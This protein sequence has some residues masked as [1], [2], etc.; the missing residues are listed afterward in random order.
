[1]IDASVHQRLAARPR[2]DLRD[3]RVPRPRRDQPRRSRPAPAGLAAIRWS[4][5]TITGATPR[6]RTSWGSGMRRRRSTRRSRSASTPSAASAG[7]RARTAASSGARC[8]PELAGD[9]PGRL[10]AADRADGHRHLAHRRRAR[11]RRRV[12]L[13]RE[14]RVRRQR[15]RVQHQRQPQH[16]A[17]PQH[18]A[19]SDELLRRHAG[20]RSAGHQPRSGARGR[21]RPR[22][23][24]STWRSAWRPAATATGS[25][26][27]SPTPTSTAAS[28]TSSAASR[29]PARRCSPASGRP[30]RWTLSRQLRGVRGPRRRRAVQ[31][32][33]RRRRPV[34]GLQDF[35]S[36]S[37]YK[38]TVR[39]QPVER[40]GAARRGEHGLP[41]A[42]AGSG[43]LLDGQ[44]EL[45]GG[46]RRA[47]AV[48]GRHLPGGQPGRARRSARRA[49]RPE[50]SEHL[51]A[52]IV[53]TPLPALSWRPT[54]TR[55]TSTTAS[56]S[57]ATSPAAR[58]R[59]CW[60]RSTPPARASSPTP[61]TPRRA[62][63][64]LR[65]GYTLRLGPAASA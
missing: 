35:G 53:W 32:P 14:H 24:R 63:Y 5:R 47:G 2:L 8:R 43:V 45:P 60:R 49:L 6:S 64:D 30:T 4:S 19:Q 41:R 59:R 62:G 21:G 23:A 65:G 9:L 38:L 18:P 44:H 51:S 15:F 7:A 36:T 31:A 56:C 52:G 26:R 48:R 50:K 29:R 28:R 33:R 40:R 20:A 10:P 17:R 27:A 58:S 1:M 3:R 54:T 22:R 25:R 39:L 46:G 61:S 37:D 13:G 57:P 12:V 55:S 16:L 34:R 42:V 11:R